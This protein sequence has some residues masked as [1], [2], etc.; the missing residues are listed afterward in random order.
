M[1]NKKSERERNS[2]NQ[3]GRGDTDGRYTPERYFGHNREVGRSRDER[4]LRADDAEQYDDHYTGKQENFEGDGYY[5]SNYGSI[6]ELNRG[7]DFEG[8]AGYRDNYEHLTTGQWPEVDRAA[9]SRGFNLQQYELEQRGV[10][11]GK[12]PKA[13]QRSDLRT[14]EDIN[15]LLTEDPYVDSSEIEVQVEKGEVTLTGTVEHKN[16]KRRVEDVV[17]RVSGVK[18][19]ENRLRTRA[20]GGRQIS[21]VRNSNE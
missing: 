6:N 18:H 4:N 20:P 21:S 3:Q 2:G 9:R 1:R 14:T 5:G 8:N 16:M 10:H 19:V 13:Y 11:R 15:D 7:R 17:E 12:G